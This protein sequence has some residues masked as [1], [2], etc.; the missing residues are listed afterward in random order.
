MELP[1]GQVWEVR[2]LLTAL[3]NKPPTKEKR[4]RK[5]RVFSLTLGSALHFI[6]KGIALVIWR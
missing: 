4:M 2:H 5:V 3:D 6:K 1:I